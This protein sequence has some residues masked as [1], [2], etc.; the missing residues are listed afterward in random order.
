MLLGIFFPFSFFFFPFQR[1]DVMGKDVCVCMSSFLGLEYSF[2]ES[3]GSYRSPPR[4]FLLGRPALTLAHPRHPPISTLHTPQSMHLLPGI[5]S[6]MGGSSLSRGLALWASDVPG[7][8]Q[9]ATWTVPSPTWL[10]VLPPT[11]LEKAG[12]VFLP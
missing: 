6:S 3:L 1:K 10:P 8:W 2:P 7:Q 11:G 5:L 4:C 12:A 9:V